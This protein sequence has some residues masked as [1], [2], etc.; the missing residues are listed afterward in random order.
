MRDVFGG[1]QGK[2]RPCALYHSMGWQDAG[3][4]IWM[5]GQSSSGRGRPSTSLCVWFLGLVLVS[6]RLASLLGL[7]IW[8]TRVPWQDHVRGGLFLGHSLAVGNGGWSWCKAHGS[9][10]HYYYFEEVC[11]Y[12]QRHTGT[13][14]HG[15]AVGAHHRAGSERRCTAAPGA[16]DPVACRLWVCR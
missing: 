6:A 7:S 4:Q 2:R 1:S 16:C 3:C 12:R 5:A 13:R 8:R 9:F 14:A 11:M 15:Q 10:C